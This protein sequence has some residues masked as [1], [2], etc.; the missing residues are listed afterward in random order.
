MTETLVTPTATIM[1]ALHCEAKPLI[2]FYRLKKVA[3]RPFALYQLVSDTERVELVVTGIGV[4]NMA[5]AIGWVGARQQTVR[6]WLNVGTAGH[7]SRKVGEVFRVHAVGDASGSRLH[8][9]PLVARWGGVSEMLWSANAPT[10]DYPDHGA[11]DMEAY[12]FFMAALKFSP[13]EL[14]QAIKVISD[15]G[16]SDIE[17]LTGAKIT[18]LMLAHQTSITAFIKSLQEICEPLCRT[19][20]QIPE[21]KGTHSQQRQLMDLMAKLTALG[22]DVNQVPTDQIPIT[23]LLVSLQQ[24]IDDAVP[25]LPNELS[26]EVPKLDRDHG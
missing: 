23:Q 1:V 14:V 5:T 15:N 16:Q 2:D 8:Y 22:I 6:S 12:G 13:A 20:M 9:P 4:L 3:D 21:V 26:K 25:E 18:D 19:P 7:A 24:Q 11:I 10:S 17:S